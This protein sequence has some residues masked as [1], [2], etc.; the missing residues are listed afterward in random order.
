MELLKKKHG[1][2]GKYG[3]Y[4]FNYIES[5]NIFICPEGNEMYPTQT[6]TTKSKSGYKSEKAIYTTDKCNC[7]PNR[8][9]CT[10][11]KTG[12]EIQQ[13]KIFEK[14]RQ[15]SLAN[16]KTEKGI[17]LRMNRYI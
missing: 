15:Q 17:L 4:N 16:I 11:S 12:K 2:Y 14:Y 10:K 5:R 6:K 7:C 1:K 13:S 8:D 3:K 9:K